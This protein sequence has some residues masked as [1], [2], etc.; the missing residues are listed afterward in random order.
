MLIHLLRLTTRCLVVRYPSRSSRM[1]SFALVGARSAASVLAGPGL[2][3][4]LS[5]IRATVLY[6]RSRRLWF[7]AIVL[8][9]HGCTSYQDGC[10]LVMTISFCSR[11]C[12]SSWSERHNMW[13]KHPSNG[14]PSKTSLIDHSPF[15]SERRRARFV[16]SCTVMTPPPL[17]GQCQVRG[18]R[19]EFSR[20]AYRSS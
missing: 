18:V 16:R 12:A 15:D 17:R 4:P 8:A 20:P 5:A 14:V 7:M 1:V 19:S 10:L 9:V 13:R 3:P 2:V 11:A 6:L